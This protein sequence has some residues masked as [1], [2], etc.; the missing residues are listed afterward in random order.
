M[1]TV[2]QLRFSEL[3]IVCG[4]ISGLFYNF[5]FHARKREISRCDCRMQCN[6]LSLLAH[7]SPGSNLS[8]GVWR[9]IQFN[10]FSR[11]VVS[12]LQPLCKV[13]C[14]CGSWPNRVVGFNCLPVVLQKYLE[15]SILCRARFYAMEWGPA[16]SVRLKLRR[17][18]VR[19][20]KISIQ[21]NRLQGIFWA[22]INILWQ[23]WVLSRDGL[24][25][26]FSTMSR[27]KSSVFH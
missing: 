13:L 1:F 12:V 9:L 8:T 5:F 21:L 16:L 23:P 22:K 17:R 27:I 11:Q 14:C 24:V 15:W 25:L 19:F 6:Y 3:K 18:G 10:W 7:S 26:R 4:L 2:F 20:P